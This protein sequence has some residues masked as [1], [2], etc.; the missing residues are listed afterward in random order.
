MSSED[1]SPHQRCR[2]FTAVPT[3]VARRLLPIPFGSPR[4]DRSGISTSSGTNSAV[5]FTCSTSGA[6]NTYTTLNR[7]NDSDDML[8]YTYYSSLAS[9]GDDRFG[10]SSSPCSPVHRVRLPSHI[11]Q[12]LPLPSAPS[13]PQ[14]PSTIITKAAATAEKGTDTAAPG[15]KSV[16]QTSIHYHHQPRAVVAAAP[17]GRASTTTT[18]AASATPKTTTS[19]ATEVEHTSSS[20]GERCSSAFQWAPLSA[21]LRQRRRLLRA[22]LTVVVATWNGSYVGYTD[23][24]TELP[25]LQKLTVNQLYHDAS[26]SASSDT[27]EK[28]KLRSSECKEREAVISRQAKDAKAA[29]SAAASAAGL[30]SL[31]STLGF[32]SDATTPTAA[33]SSSAPGEYSE[34]G[35]ASDNSTSVR[36]LC[37]TPLLPH[38]L[39][40]VQ[41]QQQQQQGEESG[42]LHLRW[43]AASTPQH[44]L[45]KQSPTGTTPGT[46]DL[47]GSS[48]CAPSSSNASRHTRGRR[49]NKATTRE[50]LTRSPQG[51]YN[52][53][54][55]EGLE[56]RRRRKK[57]KRLQRQTTPRLQPSDDSGRRTTAKYVSSGSR[58]GYD[59]NRAAFTTSASPALVMEPE[60]V[61]R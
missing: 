44:L 5:T 17:A 55:G 31:P 15:S 7:T 4:E 21:S 29:A 3:P 39:L 20:A 26:G 36:H 47:A 14:S 25:P 57:K 35:G 30:G 11:L 23:D 24:V 48:N 8:L 22:P 2:P 1:A 19:T 45:G 34:L 38:L 12:G 46:E 54:G 6:N 56:R 50:R 51:S 37:P 40:A 10:A 18:A 33:A 32:S 42:S 60:R 9:I 53:V 52:S 16:A 49:R 27:A 28:R 61:D 43:V 41:Q 13:S 58:D 59:S